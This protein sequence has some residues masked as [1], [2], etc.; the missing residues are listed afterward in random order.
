MLMVSLCGVVGHGCFTPN[1]N[2]IEISNIRYLVLTVSTNVS[3]VINPQTA[4][5]SL[6]LTIMN[7]N[8]I[9]PIHKM[10]NNS[11]I[12]HTIHIARITYGNELVVILSA[13][14]ARGLSAE[15]AYR[16]KIS[17]RWASPHPTSSQVENLE[18]CHSPARIVW[19]TIEHHHPHPPQPLPLIH[20]HYP[21]LTWTKPLI[22]HPTPNTA[23]TTCI[24]Q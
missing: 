16:C 18:T 19:N 22:T 20:H 10:Q 17:A 1:T 21:Y 12:C 3:F 5:S 15:S 11:L 13:L 6:F 4:F 2:S 24:C 7:F 8:T 23:Q 14:W 9:I